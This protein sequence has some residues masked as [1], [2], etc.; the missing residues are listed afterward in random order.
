MAQL[1]FSILICSVF[2]VVIVAWLARDSRRRHPPVTLEQLIPVHY[3]EYALLSDRLAH[4]DELLRDIESERRDAAL[5]YLDALQADFIRMEHLLR[6]AAK[7]MPD[8]KVRNELGR[9]F[10]SFSFRLE[11]RSLRL[12][13][14]LGFVPCM[15]LGALTREVTNLGK[16]TNQVLYQIASQQGLPALQADLN[17]S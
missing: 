8:L 1:S 17:R 16:W 14:R 4:Y 9:L 6:H 13:I 12:C 11:C 2:V 15:R 3:R 5:A 7:F 10:R